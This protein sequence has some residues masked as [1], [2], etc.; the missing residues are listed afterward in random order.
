M[1]IPST[2]IERSEIFDYLNGSQGRKKGEKAEN[3]VDLS[4]SLCTR[5]LLDVVQ[6]D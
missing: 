4:M 6:L 3:Q 5:L 1:E 2:C